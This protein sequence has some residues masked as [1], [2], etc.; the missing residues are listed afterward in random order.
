[1]LIWFDYLS[2]RLFVTFEQGDS[3]LCLFTFWKNFLSKSLPS[4]LS[5][6]FSA[7]PYV[8]WNSWSFNH[9]ENQSVAP[10]TLSCWSRHLTGLTWAA[11]IRPDGGLL[12]GGLALFAVGWL[13]FSICPSMVSKKSES[14]SSSSSCWCCLV[15]T[16]AASSLFLEKFGKK[17]VSF[18]NLTSWKG[19]RRYERFQKKRKKGGVN[20]IFFLV[21]SFLLTNGCR[22]RATAASGSFTECVWL[23]QVSAE[24]SYRRL[25]GPS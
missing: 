25:K 5:T 20:S 14:F 15:E 13:S 21:C 7:Q 3:A 1:M 11:V 4:L 24:P 19:R 23:V 6:D 2:V 22:C 8:G 10:A 16:A 12:C 9:T 18:Y 17:N